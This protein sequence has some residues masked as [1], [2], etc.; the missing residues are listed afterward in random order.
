MEGHGPRQTAVHSAQGMRKHADQWPD[1]QNP[2]AA[3]LLL[4]R[5][6]P[7]YEPEGMQT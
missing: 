7:K 1:I 3:S 6:E 5:L 4:V 2:D